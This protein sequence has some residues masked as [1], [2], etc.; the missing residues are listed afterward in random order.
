MISNDFLSNTISYFRRFWVLAFLLAFWGCMSHTQMPSQVPGAAMDADD[1]FFQ[2]GETLLSQGQAEDALG[3]YSRYLGR[4][5]QGRHAA[6]A[7]LRIGAIYQERGALGPAQAFYRSLIEK[8]PDADESK[9][10][11][12]ALIDILIKEN[13][14]SEAGE[15]AAGTLALD[16][17]ESQRRGLL[18][19][20]VNLSRSTQDAAHTALYAYLLYKSLSPPQNETWYKLLLETIKEVDAADIAALWDHIDDRQI[21]SDLMYRYAAMQVV[22]ENYDDAMDLLMAFVTIFPEH[23]YVAE[24]QGLIEN[25][26]QRLRFTPNTIGCLLPLSGAYETYGQRALNAVEMA[27]SLQQTTDRALPIKLVVKDTAS[28]DIRAAAA[29]RELAQAGVGAI[30][31]P[32][33]TALAAAHEAQRLNIPIVTFTQKPEITATGDFVFRHFITPHNQVKTLVEYFVGELGLR[34][35]AVMYPREVYGETFLNLFWEEVIRQG[36]NMVGAESYVTGQTDFAET[37]KKL[38]GTYYSIPSDLEVKPL[39]EVEERP[40]YS[41]GSLSA[42]SLEDMLPDPVNRLTGLFF[43]DPDQDRIKGP[44]TGRRSKDDTEAPIVDFD[45]LFIPDA[46][47]ATGLI[48]PQLAYHDV[49]NIYT[50]GTNLWH[51]QQLIDMT[52]KYAQNA[53]MVDGF[54]KDSESGT[55]RRFVE[56]YRTIYGSDPGVVEAFAFDTANLLF[57]LIVQPDIR[58]R[59][60]LRNAMCQ[61]YSTDGVT[62]ATAF[63]PDGEA[64]KRL[65]LLRIKGDRFVEIAHP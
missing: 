31:G 62:G 42:D 47:N 44:K 61:L 14:L 30:I 55:V 54:Y 29:V 9:Q 36:G 22:A 7:L 46:P 45:V 40:Y 64:I 16:L 4:F 49:R 63:A 48:L 1:I 51:S 23:P 41:E 37:I 18:E 21:R 52:H 65:T 27:L 6:L 34:K 43:Q 38:T 13:R 57:Q 39:V 60:E 8:F 11:R 19:R 10:A 12:L 35:F 20:L 32:M 24:A 17:D 3:E 25:L 15:L 26:D 28:D 50:V 53:V 59:H 56:N 5:P 58:W 2:K 33:A